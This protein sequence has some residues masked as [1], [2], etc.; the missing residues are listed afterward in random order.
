VSGEILRE[1]SVT[2]FARNYI[3]GDPNLVLSEGCDIPREGFL[4]CGV[5]KRILR[6]NEN[7]KANVGCII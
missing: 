5:E 3:P 7:G 2:L 6:C 1:S 4:V